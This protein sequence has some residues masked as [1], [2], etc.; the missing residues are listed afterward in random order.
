M[1]NPVAAE[2]ALR[3]RLFACGFVSAELL[4]AVIDDEICGLNR[5]LELRREQLAFALL[6]LLRK[7][8]LDLLDLND[9]LVAERFKRP[10]LKVV[11]VADTLA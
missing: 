10:L 11:L 3:L 4:L 2:R 1:F 5:F 6:A 7:L 9:V 8:Q